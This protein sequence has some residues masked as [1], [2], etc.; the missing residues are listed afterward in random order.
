MMIM[1]K[2]MITVNGDDEDGCGGDNDNDQDWWKL[3]DLT[4]AQSRNKNPK[5]S[6]KKFLK[7]PGLKIRINP[8]SKNHGIENL[9][10]VRAWSWGIEAT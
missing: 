5:K 6:L 7:I 1:I 9:D 2:I 3:C 4:S 10:P 8:V